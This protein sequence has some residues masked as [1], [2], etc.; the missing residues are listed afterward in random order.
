MLYLFHLTKFFLC[1]ALCYWY[2]KTYFSAYLLALPLL[3]SL[4]AIKLLSTK[5]NRQERNGAFLYPTILKILQ[6][7]FVKQ[8]LF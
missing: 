5:I 4:P 6:N 1:L 2:H 3:L 8:S 7:C